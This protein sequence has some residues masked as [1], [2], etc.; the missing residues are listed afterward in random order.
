MKSI[1]III[2]TYND[3]E[4]VK[5]KINNCLMLKYM[6]HMVEIIVV[7]GGA[8]LNNITVM[9]ERNPLIRW[10][11]TTIVGKIHQLNIA[12]KEARGDIIIITD[13]DTSV[14]PLAVW[15]TVRALSHKEAGLVGLWCN[16][17]G[18]W[19]DKIYWYVANIIRTIDKSHVVAPFY[20][21]NKL[22][23]T[24]FPRDVIADDFYISLFFLFIGKKISFIRTSY[25]T[26]FRAPLTIKEFIKHKTRKGNAV[27]RELL[28]FLYRIN[29][30]TTR[31]KIIFFLR[32]F[33]FTILT[34][35]IFISYLWYKQTSA[36]E[37]L[38]AK[39]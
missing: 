27:L 29:E 28:R 13:V 30:A 36:Y 39:T 24:Q 6:P 14:T 32:L 15:D 37:K 25:V 8:Q 9:Q 21:F 2:P 11:D 18:N 7:R 10:I 23:F 16:V 34:P 17:R 35:T 12:L 3:D 20:A 33:Q 19:I 38:T 1:T 26:E 31:V 5:Q 22:D 4:Y